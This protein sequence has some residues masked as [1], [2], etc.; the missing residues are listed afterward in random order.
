METRKSPETHRRDLVG[1]VVFPKSS[2]NSWEKRNDEGRSNSMYLA[3]IEA[4]LQTLEEQEED[5]TAFSPLEET[6]S[7]SSSNDDTNDT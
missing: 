6:T 5:S 2:E 3:D 1:P 7:E 4:T